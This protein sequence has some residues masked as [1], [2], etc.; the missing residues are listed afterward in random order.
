MA[1]LLDRYDE[2]QRRPFGSNTALSAGNTN[3]LGGVAGSQFRRQEAAYGQALRTLNRAA[4]RGDARAAL[5]AID[6]REQAMEAGFAPGGIRRSEIANAGIRGQ[7]AGMEQA[8]TERAK[9]SRILQMQAE[10]SMR[11]AGDMTEESMGTSEERRRVAEEQKRTEGQQTASTGTTGGAAE[12]KPAATA[13]TGTTGG[14]AETKPAA[15]AGTAATAAR[16][17]VPMPTATYSTSGG[18]YTGRT[19]TPTPAAQAATSAPPTEKTAAQKYAEAQERYQ[20][21]L[22]GV[23]DTQGA[24]SQQGVPNTDNFAEMNRIYSGAD[25]QGQADIVAQSLKRAAGLNRFDTAGAPR[26]SRI[27]K[28]VSKSDTTKRTSRTNLRK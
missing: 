19:P 6:V 2:M 12:T 17:R 21:Y 10:E 18:D 23:E 3:N 9:Q 14:A 27:I 26:A 16:P 15:T 5:G 1:G 24:Y 8:A 25:S 20:K 4:R 13:G 7:V 11:N 28:E 22:T